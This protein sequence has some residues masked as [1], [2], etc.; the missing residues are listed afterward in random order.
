[1]GG[2]LEVGKLVAASWLYRNWSHAPK[3]IK[4]YLTFAVLILTVISSVG[5]FGFLSSSHIDA[6]IA[7]R[8]S[9]SVDI[10]ETDAKIERLK[11]DVVD[12]DKTIGQIDQAIQKLLDSGKANSS[13][14]AATNQR[15]TRDS[16]VAK[17]DAAARELTDL[18]VKKAGLD[19]NRKKIEAEV[20]PLKYVAVAVFGSADE[21]QLEKAVR[22]LI[23]VFVSVFDPLAI[24]LLISA[25]HGMT[26]KKR[27]KDGV[28]LS[29]DDILKIH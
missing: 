28:T 11:R 13:L 1:M 7:M 20:G 2:A 27:E 19:A 24:V 18:E 5:I 12:L 29:S 16:M 22:I 4:A 17:R 21:D 8:N 23:V 6:T 15:K 26:K 25:S 9:G 14:V 10:A 3:F